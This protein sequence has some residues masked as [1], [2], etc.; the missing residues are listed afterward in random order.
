MLYIDLELVSRE[1][2]EKVINYLNETKLLKTTYD[3]VED[4]FK[5]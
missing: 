2:K 1:D 5:L 3:P 4:L